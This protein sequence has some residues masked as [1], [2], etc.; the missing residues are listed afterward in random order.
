MPAI[1]R[2]TEANLWGLTITTVAGIEVTFAPPSDEEGDGALVPWRP[3]SP[4]PVSAAAFAAE[5]DWF[6][7]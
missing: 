1:V 4:A 7:V 5:R 6:Y 2:T 3:K